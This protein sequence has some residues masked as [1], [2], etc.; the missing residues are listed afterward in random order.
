MRATFKAS[1]SP[2]TAL[3][4]GGQDACRRRDLNPCI[5]V[6]TWCSPR[7][8]YYDG[9]R[10]LSG[11]YQLQPFPAGIYQGASQP[12]GGHPTDTACRG[13]GSNHHCACFQVPL[14]EPYEE[15][16]NPCW[17][18]TASA[19]GRSAPWSFDIERSASLFHPHRVF[20]RSIGLGVLGGFEPPSS[21]VALP[22][23]R[24]VCKEDS[25]KVIVPR[26]RSG[27]G[28]LPT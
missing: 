24:A 13:V 8:S 5:Q 4:L 10:L 7:L 16:G 12:Y 21:L 1:C 15:L 27:T 17:A 23:C 18:T 2:S 25:G 3:V 22:D 20:Q 28:A 14:P 6:H 19:D 26:E 9:R 11:F